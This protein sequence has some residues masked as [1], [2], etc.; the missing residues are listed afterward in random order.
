MSNLI[1]R[2]SVILLILSM[3]YGCASKIMIPASP[4]TSP[5]NEKALVTFLMS[6]SWQNHAGRRS[7][8]PEEFDIWDSEKFIGAL[9][10]NT[11]FQYVADPG[12]HLFVARG[13]NW[14]FVKADLRSGKRY[15]VFLNAYPM[16]FRRDGVILQPVTV[17][18]KALIAEVPWYLDNLKPVSVIKERY[19]DY[20]KD[21]IIEVK[22]E[23][24]IFSQSTEY[25]F[26]SLE[27]QDGL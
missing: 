2:L 15:Y 12:E 19:G 14:S 3:L 5:N 21:R 6:S 7:G 9:S 20:I 13:G 23:I 26:S 8:P 1:N 16:F 27:A 17:G 11:Y 22:N 10:I 18:D 25:G 4:V 24:I